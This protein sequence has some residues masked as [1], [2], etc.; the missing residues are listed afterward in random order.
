MFLIS[1]YLGNLGEGKNISCNRTGS[2]SLSGLKFLWVYW[3]LSEFPIF[4]IEQWVGHQ[5]SEALGAG[6]NSSIY[7]YVFSL[8]VRVMRV[9]SST[10]IKIII[11]CRFLVV[12]LIIIKL[13]FVAISK[14]YD[15]NRLF[16]ITTNFSLFSLIVFPG[17]LFWSMQVQFMP[18]TSR[19]LLMPKGLSGKKYGA[20]R[21]W[22]STKNR[23]TPLTHSFSRLETFRNTE[24]YP[25][26]NFSCREKF[27]DIFLEYSVYGVSVFFVPN[28]W[29]APE[30]PG[31]SRNTKR[32]LLQ[33]FQLRDTVRY[34]IFDTF[35]WYLSIGYRNSH[36]EQ[37]K[38][39]DYERFSTGFGFRS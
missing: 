24:R 3:N 2:E 27:F 32:S 36:A 38:G 14:F 16:K 8:S 22:V 33:I 1:L 25:S 9:L 12:A 21:Q 19:F 15:N 35:W 30:T 5:G 39:V 7:L 4:S 37:T 26:R 6:W 31:T 18:S 34:K 13:T 10:L 29:T 17:T 23:D 20:A 28:S 11:F